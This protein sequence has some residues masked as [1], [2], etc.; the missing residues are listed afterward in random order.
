MFGIPRANTPETPP[1]LK[2]NLNILKAA[3]GG[4]IIFIGNIFEAGS[5]FIFAILLTRLLGA[6]QF[7]LYRL[8]LT[9]GT[10]GAGLSLFGLNTALVRYVALFAGRRDSAGVWGTIQIAL[11]LSTILS[12]LLGLGLFLFADPIAIRIFDEPHL[13]GLLRLTTPVIPILALST[14]L[15]AATQGFKRMEY[16]VIANNLTIPLIKLGLIVALALTVGLNATNA[17]II[18]IIALLVACGMLVY[19]L[20]SLF[21]LTRAVNTARY[22]V[23]EILNFSWPLYLSD[24]IGTFKGNIQT[25]LLGSLNSITNVGIFA[26][27]SQVNSIGIMFHRSIVTISRPIVSEL[28][29]QGEYDQL[30]RF[31]QTITKWTLTLNLPLV[32]LIFLFPNQILSIFGRT[33][34]NGNTALTILA[35]ATL[36]NAGTG[37][38]GVILDMTGKTTLKFFNSILVFGLT[39]GLNIWLIPRWGLVG[40]AVSSLLAVVII[41][42][43]RLVEVYILF[44]LFPYNLSFLKPLA[45]TA[46]AV[47]SVFI[48][49]QFLPGQLNIFY[50]I[51][52]AVT[53]LITYA[54][55]ILALGLSPEDRFL[56]NRIYNRIAGK[57]FNNKHAPEDVTL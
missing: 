8:A 40:A 20:N 49:N 47:G 43:L 51:T 46:G 5:R 22:E 7:G 42:L 19:Y 39:I 4:S 6:E 57:L 13:A 56:L 14:G 18:H 11:G 36:A 10:V 45:A 27:A 50:T 16:T 15:S 24:L 31:Y 25:V 28:Y 35:W 52:N 21:S 3:K 37:I 30:S 9:A 32:L 44:K 53:L 33:F 48:V 23:K 2:S 55:F 26:V 1:Q 41:N 54:G 38:C 29:D 34:V 12:M 17:L